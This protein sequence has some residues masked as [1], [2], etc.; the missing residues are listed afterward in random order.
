MPPLASSSESALATVV[1]T[2]CSRRAWS[3][4]GF[5]WSTSSLANTRS[6]SRWTTCALACDRCNLF[7]GPNLSSID[8]EAN[9]VVRLFHPRRDRWFDHFQIRGAFIQG[10]KPTGRATAQLLQFNAKRRVELRSALMAAG[11]YPGEL[12]S[13]LR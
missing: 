9:E 10:F 2:A 6:T 11:D 5:T 3:T 1:S 13:S 4:A 8:P 7:K 12:G